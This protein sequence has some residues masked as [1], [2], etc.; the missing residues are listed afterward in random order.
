MTIWISNCSQI[1]TPLVGQ[2]IKINNKHICI[3]RNA[4]AEKKNKMNKNMNTNQA[5]T[6]HKK[7]K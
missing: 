7:T 6:T 2:S 3:H 5:R 4:D 1:A